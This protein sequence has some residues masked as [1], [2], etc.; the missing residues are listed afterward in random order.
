MAVAFD[1]PWNRGL[2][3]EIDHLGRRPD[4]R[5]NLRVG[6]DGRDAVAAHRQGLRPGWPSFTVM[7]LP[8]RSH[9]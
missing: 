9:Q 1:E 8:L 6:A 3:R 2:S 5:R 4:Q 7:M